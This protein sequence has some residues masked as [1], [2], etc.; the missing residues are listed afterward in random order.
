MLREFLRE[1]VEQ[2]SIRA[3]GRIATQTISLVAS[4]LSYNLSGD[5]SG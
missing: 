3:G 5:P 1:A 2:W 4:Q